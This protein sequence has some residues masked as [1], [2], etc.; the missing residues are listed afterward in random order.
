[1]P[2]LANQL[3]QETLNL[4]L[5]VYNKNGLTNGGRLILDGMLQRHL[6]V[7][8]KAYTALLTSLC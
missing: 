4:L 1:M 5:K 3:D 6:I 2:E 8:N 7:K